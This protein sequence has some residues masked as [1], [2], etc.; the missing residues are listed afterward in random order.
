MPEAKAIKIEFKNADSLLF[1]DEN[2]R[3]SSFGDSTT[4]DAL[5]RTLWDEMAVSEVALSIAANGYFEE[6]PLFIVPGDEKNPDQKGKWIVVEGNRR[7][8][9]VRL[10]CSAELRRALGA[11]DLPAIT[12]QQRAELAQLPVSVYPNKKALWEYFGFRHVNGP[13]EWDSFSKAA[14]IASVRRKYGVP[15][16]EIARKIGDQHSTVTRIYR[17]FVLLEQAEKMTDFKRDDR[18]ANRFYFS[19]LY[20]AADQREFQEFLGMDPA[21][22]LRDSPV[23]TRHLPQLQELMVWLFGSKSENKSPVVEQQNPHLKWLRRV[24]GNRQ[25]LYALRSGISLQRSHE[26]SLGDDRRFQEAL[27]KAKDAL[28]EAKATV[29]T[30]YKGEKESLRVMD[31]LLDLAR[32]IAEEMHAKAKG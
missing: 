25:A 8:A 31:G 11:T 14:Y 16:E 20:T 17:G 23:P 1:D 2:P 5:L 24:I 28:Q 4:Q 30:G 21:R 7:L 3:L 12:A 10:L 9:A 29:T 22:S 13:K 32:S 27:I 18:I 15:L 19:H 6:E 26:I